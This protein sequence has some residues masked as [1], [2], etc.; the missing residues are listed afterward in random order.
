MLAE[1]AGIVA[2]TLVGAVIGYLWARLGHEFATDFV[3]KLV[4]NVGAPCLIFAS[5]T[6][7]H[8]TA[9]TFGVMSLAAA[10]SMAIYLVAGLAFLRIT[11]MK[12]RPYLS[13]I[14]FP[15]LGNMGLPICLFAYGEQGLAL[16]LGFFVVGAAA[17]NTL[18][19][20]L[21]DGST[22]LKSLLKLPLI[23][24]VPFGLA[25]AIPGIK[26][27]V[28]LF[29]STHLIGQL[30]IPLM[31]IALGAS[32][33]RLRFH[34][35]G[36]PIMMSCLRLTMGPAVGLGIAWLMGLEGMQRGVVIL[37][38]SMPVAVLNYLLAARYNQEPE[39]VAGIVTI[40]TVMSYVTLPVILWFLLR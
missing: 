39:D 14:V 23:Y 25:F 35:L 18:G 26:P 27:P 31:L 22:S 38:C 13:T 6:S 24:A 8:I 21:M 32:L 5:L 34:A 1:L 16:A 9:A 11:R 36:R 29:N 30:A 40:S 19:I 15:N 28:W 4:M 3:T 2:P 12:I 33:A 7:L 10:I 17:Q 20:W 37:E